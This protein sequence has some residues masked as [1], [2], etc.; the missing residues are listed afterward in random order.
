[1][2]EIMFPGTLLMGKVVISHEAGY[3]F[4]A[5]GSAFSS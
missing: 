1:M 2:Q 3:I 4:E 5:N